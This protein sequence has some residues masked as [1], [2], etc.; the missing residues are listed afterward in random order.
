MGCRET[1]FLVIYTFHPM[2][3]ISKRLYNS[4]IAA[5]PKAGK[6]VWWLL[7]I[8]L[9]ISLAVSLLQ[10]WGIIA[11]MATV[12][13]PVFS[14][15]GLPGE[16]AIV[17]ISSIFLTLY[18]PI[19]IIATL[20]LDIREITILALMCLISHNMFVETAIQKKTG[21]SAVVMFSL[22][23]CASF[24]S[25]YILNLLLPEQLGSGQAIKEQVVSANIGNMLTIWL[26]S[27]GWLILKISLIVTGLMILQ[28]IMKDFKILNLISKVIA[29]FMSVLG[30]SKDSS[31]LWFVAQMLG[32]TY[33]SAVMIEAVGQKEITPANAN[34]LNYHIAMNHSLLEDTLLFVAIGVPAG[35]I[36]AP[37]FA[38]AIIVVWS[39]RL[40]IRLKNREKARI[41]KPSLE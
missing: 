40:I 32:L 20:P 15:I 17:F 18:A 30:L 23:L 19:A 12:L 7:K 21:S 1:T 13:A 10:Y 2:S 16:S 4:T 34:L 11:Q 29:P 31:F 8:I 37:R 36:I 25:A 39:V 28:N 6:T 5:F 33:G 41:I 3:K 35:W 9:P 27:A 24:I 22:R 14:L 26:I 38:L